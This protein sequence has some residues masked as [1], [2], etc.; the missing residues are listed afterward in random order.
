MATKTK[1]KNKKPLFSRTVSVTQKHIDNS[2]PGNSTECAIAVAVREHFESLG[3]GANDIEITGS[4]KRSLSLTLG[5][6]FPKVLD[7]FIDKY[8]TTEPVAES[9]ETTAEFKAAHKKWKN[10]VKPFSFTF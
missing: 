7:S 9:F 3:F 5:V 8:D 10:R 6:K 4:G 1:K 2:I